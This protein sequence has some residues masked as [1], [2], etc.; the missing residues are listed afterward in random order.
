MVRRLALSVFALVSA[1]VVVVVPAASA[2]PGY[3]GIEWGSSPKVASPTASGNLTDIRSGR[4][5]CYDRLVF[6]FR[7][8]ND[9]Y[10]VQY[11]D[12]VYEDGSGRLVPLRGGAKLQVVV[13]SPAYDD[14]GNPTYTYPN[15]AELVDV[16]GYSTFRQV[17]W[18]GSFEGQTTVGLGVRARLPFRVFTLP[19][20]VVVD[21]AHLW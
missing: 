16:T 15:R 6:D 7:G 2:A 11:V 3:C 18:A 10:F 4:Q 5:D 14:A 1:L 21:V 8:T 20:R 13:Y 17:A 9:G 19:G 12:D